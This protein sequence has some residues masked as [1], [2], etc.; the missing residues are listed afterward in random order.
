MTYCDDMYIFLY[1]LLTK[2]FHQSILRFTKAKAGVSKINS[3]LLN[4]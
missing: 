2:T 3:S 1:V 4:Q